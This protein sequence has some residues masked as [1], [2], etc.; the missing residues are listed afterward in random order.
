MKVKH[1]KDL[2]TELSKW[3]KI[4][5]KEEVFQKIYCTKKLKIYYSLSF[6]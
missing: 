3:E 1:E 5:E 2:I 6:H 4:E